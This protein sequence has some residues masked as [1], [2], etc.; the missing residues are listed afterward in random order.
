[1]AFSRDPYGRSPRSV[2]IMPTEHEHD[3]IAE[4]LLGH[5]LIL[6]AV[7]SRTVSR[8]PQ[9]ALLAA[10]TGYLSC[11]VTE[12]FA[13]PEE[14]FADAIWPRLTIR[15]EKERRVLMQELRTSGM[16]ALGCI[17]GQLTDAYAA[18]STRLPH[19]A[20]AAFID[21]IKPS[22]AFPPLPQELQDILTPYWDGNRPAKISELAYALCGGALWN[23]FV[24]QP[25]LASALDIEDFH[26]ARARE[27]KPDS[28]VATRILAAL[29]LGGFVDTAA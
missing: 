10:D 8:V 23:E 16:L 20:S 9:E 13:F 24:V 12:L 2:W 25:G 7:N 28:A 17:P 5:E 1:M 6:L 21:Q 3:E 19:G 22:E 15:L 18:L 27:T 4:W 26:M 14:M 11:R 29:L